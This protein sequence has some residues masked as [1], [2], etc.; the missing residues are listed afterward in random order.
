MVDSPEMVMLSAAAV[1]PAPPAFFSAFFSVFF[2]VLFAAGSFSSACCSIRV[3]PDLFFF[4]AKASGAMHR[5]TSVRTVRNR[6][7][8]F[9][10]CFMGMPLL[11]CF[12]SV[13]RARSD[14]ARDLFFSG[15]Y[16]DK[17]CQYG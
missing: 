14:H 1:F 6:N 13:F 10:R 5:K 11:L 9:I 3:S 17:L 15:L 12:V 7:T 16:D 2:P 4:S 8:L